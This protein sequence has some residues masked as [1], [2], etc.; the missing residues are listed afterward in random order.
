MASFTFYMLFLQTE[1]FSLFVYHDEVTK[2]FLRLRSYCLIILPQSYHDIG[3]IT[4][5][6]QT[7]ICDTTTIRAKINVQYNIPG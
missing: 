5:E 1:R 4:C 2:F 7:H 6:G 3:Y